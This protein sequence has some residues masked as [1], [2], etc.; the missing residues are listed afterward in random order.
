VD[1]DADNWD[2]VDAGYWWCTS[3][4]RWVPPDEPCEGCLARDHDEEQRERNE[5]LAD[6][7]GGDNGTQNL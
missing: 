5:S 6:T 1:S 7:P 2:E 4:R 3:C